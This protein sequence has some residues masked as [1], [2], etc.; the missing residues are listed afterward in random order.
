MLLGY[1]KDRLQLLFIIAII[2][3]LIGMISLI[4]SFIKGEPNIVLP[5]LYLVQ[6]IL[7]YGVYIYCKVKKYLLINKDYIQRNS[8]SKPKA[9]INDILKVRK[10]GNVYYL[11]T[12]KRTL[13]IN[14]KL[15]DNQALIELENFLKNLPKAVVV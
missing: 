14:T 5:V 3:F 1:K 13:R 12:S 7:F 8:P 2:W 4:I 9:H 10:K 6:S 15:L 11:Y